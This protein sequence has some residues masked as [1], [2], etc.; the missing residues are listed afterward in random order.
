MASVLLGMQPSKHVV[1]VG[2]CCSAGISIADV[3]RSVCIVLV[4]VNP[5]IPLPRAP[6]TRRRPW[7]P[8]DAVRYTQTVNRVLFR[9]NRTMDLA[10]LDHLG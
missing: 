10:A 9:D 4:G 8:V 6:S 1:E 3:H 5:I 2:I 7:I